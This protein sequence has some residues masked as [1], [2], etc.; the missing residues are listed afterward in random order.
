MKTLDQVEARTPISS[1]PFV[2]TTSGSYYLVGSLT[3]SQGTN[4]IT[5]AVDNVS[6]DLNGFALIGK[7]GS[8]NG[9]FAT[10]SIRNISV[11][12]GTVRNWG[13]S[14]I[15]A[16]N[17]LNGLFEEV[18]ADSNSGIGID[19][20]N[21]AVISKCVSISNGGI[22]I[23]GGNGSSIKDCTAES[24]GGAG[25]NSSSGSTITGCASQYNTGVGI[26]ASPG[27]SIKNC[28]VQS[29]GGGGISA[30]GA[31][32]IVGC[33]VY[34]NTGIGIS[35]FLSTVQDCTVI[36]NTGDG[37]YMVS[38][39]VILNNNAYG[40]GG[41]TASNNNIH[42]SGSYNRIEGNHVT[43]GYTGIRVDTSGN[44][45]IKNSSGGQ[46]AANYIVAAGNLF[47]PTLSSLAALATNSNPHANYD[48]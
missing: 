48:F 7:P 6:I 14:G 34:S 28:S 40:N 10:P 26:L 4:G 12:N 36:N 38:Y 8:S 23:N 5:V 22:G 35:T 20:G 45:I 30:A 17:T 13:R 37:I 11:R 21:G 42:V 3:A 41:F 2:I 1:L 19:T 18:R 39:G 31:C 9:V 24:N 15:A 47:G 32:N 33:A 16:T 44:V 43:L 25:I 46:G 27:T 29:N